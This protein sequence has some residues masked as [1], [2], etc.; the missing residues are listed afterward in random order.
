MARSFSSSQP[1]AKVAGGPKALVVVELEGGNDGLNTVI[2]FEDDQY[3]RLR[4]NLAIPRGQVLRLEGASGVGLHPA[5]SALQ[6][7]YGQGRLAIVQGVGY[8]NPTYSHFEASD[9]WQSAQSQPKADR[10]GWLGRY[11]ETR[12]EGNRKAASLVGESPLALYSRTTL[13]PA[14]NGL[15]DFKFQ[16]DDYYYDG[17][18]LQRLQLAR[19]IYQQVS[20][21]GLT[22]YVRASALDALATADVLTRQTQELG[23]RKGY[24]PDSDL[25][26]QLA[27]VVRLLLAGL[28]FRIFYV[29]LSGFDTHS[30]QSDQHASLLKDLS[31]SLA[32]FYADLGQVGLA[33]Q[34]VTL[35]FSEF[36]RRPEE[37]GGGTDHGSAQ[38]L[39]VL[40]GKVRGG[41]Y[42]QASSLSDLEEGNLKYRVD[43]RQ[44]YAT[45]LKQWLEVEPESLL[46]GNWQLLSFM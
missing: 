43:F 11:L 16:A 33:E 24:P 17:D 25:A 29:R 32:A 5:M 19:Q 7:L 18:G 13:V 20:Q 28:D 9:I 34:V 8:P 36:G 45:V 3:Y 21:D 14:I 23:E 10:S 22:E 30:N 15:E 40:G 39:L 31:E 38:P 42:G 44:V 46:G 26:R 37:N 35:T 2:P 6:K 41:L 1:G 12:P 4:P 27:A